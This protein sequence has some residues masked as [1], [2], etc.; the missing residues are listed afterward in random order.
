MSPILF[1]AEQQLTVSLHESL[2]TIFIITRFVWNDESRNSLL[3]F[4]FGELIQ[5]VF[6]FLSKLTDYPIAMH[7]KVITFL[8]RHLERLIAKG[9]ETGVTIGFWEK[10]NCNWEHRV[11][12]IAHIFSR[13]DRLNTNKSLFVMLENCRQLHYIFI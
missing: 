5:I 7:T 10:W 12:R 13:L 9:A 8:E 4:F 1:E 6:Q 11:P 3:D 2:R